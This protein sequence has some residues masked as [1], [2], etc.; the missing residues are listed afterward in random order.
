MPSGFL[1]N[2]AVSFDSSSDILPLSSRLIPIAPSDSN[3]PTPKNRD[4]I[5]CDNVA[6]DPQRRLR[7]EQDAG[8]QVFGVELGHLVERVAERIVRRHKLLDVAHERAARRL[9]AHRHRL[10]RAVVDRQVEAVDDV[11]ECRSCDELISTPP[12]PLDAVQH[13]RVAAAA[14]FLQR[15]AP[16]RS[17]RPAARSPRRTC[18]PKSTAAAAMPS[19]SRL[20]V[21]PRSRALIFVDDVA[22]RVVGVDRHRRGRRAVDHLRRHAVDGRFRPTCR[23]AA[24]PWPSC[25]CRPRQP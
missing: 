14:D 12:E 16:C 7:A 2:A 25:R 23:E 11:L 24:D 5:T 20:A 1:L 17:Y 19:F 10:Q 15:R 18:P 8:R 13:E 3:S 6:I 4:V 22:Q 21:T 9:D